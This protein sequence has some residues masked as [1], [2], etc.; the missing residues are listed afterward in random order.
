MTYQGWDNIET[1]VVAELIDG[2]KELLGKIYEAYRKSTERGH[3]K[4][5]GTVAALATS[6]EFEHEKLSK[7]DISQVNFRGL[8]FYYEQKA[9]LEAK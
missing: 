3:A 8:A 4:L 2:D 6:S 5:I 1:Y 9:S 7:L